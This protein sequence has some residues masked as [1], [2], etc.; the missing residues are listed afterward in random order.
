MAKAAPRKATKP[1]PKAAKPTRKSNAAKTKAVAKTATPTKKLTSVKAPVVSKDELRV[2]LEK[3]HATIATLRTKARDATRVAKASAA[4][5]IELEAKVAKLEKK[6]SVQ[7][8]LALQD[9]NSAKP[10]KRRG[11]KVAEKAD[12]AVA[13]ET[14][15]Q[16]ETESAPREND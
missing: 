6:S 8:K 11:R 14:T 10:A 13:S 1:A 4:Q 9:T 3:A 2:K 7:D 16:D 12:V 5:L 15:D